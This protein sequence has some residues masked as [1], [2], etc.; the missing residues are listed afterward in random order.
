[1]IYNEFFLLYIHICIVYMLLMLNIF[2]YCNNINIH[3]KI[4]KIGS[5]VCMFVRKFLCTENFLRN[6]I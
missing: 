5:V 3:V 1:M 4:F 2:L 6:C